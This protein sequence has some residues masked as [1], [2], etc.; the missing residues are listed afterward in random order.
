MSV[1]VEPVSPAELAGLPTGESSAVVARRVAAA[2]EIQAARQDGLTN[3]EAPPDLF[4]I[5]AL[6]RDYAVRAADR[7]RLSAR[8]FTRLLRVARTI[9]DLAG[10]TETGQPH[11]AEAL[12]YRL[13]RPDRRS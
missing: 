1:H 8:G 11:V 7:L 6:A 3:A 13:R 12:T 10:D 4:P 2:R 5:N 9:A